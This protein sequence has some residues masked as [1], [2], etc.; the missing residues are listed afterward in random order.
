MCTQVRAPRRI[1]I[2]VY[3]WL[4]FTSISCLR[5]THAPA[6]Q[7]PVA[8]NSYL[9]LAPGGSL[10]IVVPLLKSG[11]LPLETLLLQQD[12]DTFL[13]SAANLAGYDISFYSI[14]RAP[15][16]RVR[17]KFTTAEITR[18]SKTVSD[19]QAPALPFALPLTPQHIRLFYFVRK[20]QSDHNMAIL[21]SK[22][23]AALNTFTKQ[24]ENHPDVCGTDGEISCSWVPAGIAVRPESEPPPKP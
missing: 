22:N 13:V 24:L 4:L 2:P 16:G 12:G 7:T 17:L 19:S 20:S 14:D 9:D 10:R 3:A 5:K 23:L 1:V 15:H 8:D 11:A 21:A 6:S 18:D